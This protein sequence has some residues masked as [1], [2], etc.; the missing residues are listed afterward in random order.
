MPFSI[1]GLNDLIK[2]H[3][4]SDEW[5]ILAIAC[6]IRVCEC[7]G[8]EVAEFGDVAHV[9]DPLG[10][11]KRKSPAHG[12]VSLL[13]GSHHARKVPV[14]EGRDDERMSRKPGILHD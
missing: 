9:N 1:K 11:I 8:H 4:I 12:S 2:A 14:V 10:G 13:L 3:E 6:L 5:Q 7:A